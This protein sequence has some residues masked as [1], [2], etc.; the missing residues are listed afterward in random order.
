MYVL[1]PL[2]IAEAMVAKRKM[3]YRD[4]KGWVNLLGCP[5]E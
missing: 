4:A 5:S 1:L 3:S 2:H